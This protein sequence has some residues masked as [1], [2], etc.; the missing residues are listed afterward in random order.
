MPRILYSP[1]AESDLT[2]LWRYI[3]ADALLRSVGR[4]CSLLA[5]RPG[6]GRDRSDIL[7][8]LLSFPVGT[9]LIFYRIAEGG[10]EIVR[11]LHGARDVPSIFEE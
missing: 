4:T 2:D 7:G 3:A 8:G 10:L 1:L 6:I 9:Y 5:D 11:V